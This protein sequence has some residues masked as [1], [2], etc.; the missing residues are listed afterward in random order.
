M[1]LQI[2][3]QQVEGAA[4]LSRV[5]RQALRADA[6]DGS[7]EGAESEALEAGRRLAFEAVVE[8]PAAVGR[9]ALVTGHAPAFQLITDS[10]RQ[11]RRQRRV[12]QAHL[13]RIGG[14]VEHHLGHHP[15]GDA[16]A[17]CRPWV[18]RAAECAAPGHPDAGQERALALALLRALART[19]DTHAVRRESV[20]APYHRRAVGRLQA[21]GTQRQRVGPNS[22]DESL[23]ALV[24]QQ[25]EARRAG[26][27][28]ESQ[29]NFH[30]S[31]VSLVQRPFRVSRLSLGA[32]DR[33]DASR[34]RVQCRHA[35]LRHGAA[36]CCPQ[37]ARQ[38]PGAA[39]RQHGL[40]FSP[41]AP[42]APRKRRCPP[43][44]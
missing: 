25:R 35:C 14:A 39:Q 5:D 40:A 37:P 33:R 30:R 36:R 10:L 29:F 26:G 27:V 43:S 9:A 20:L 21:R 19:A 28:G 22:V 8:L 13:R 44:A 42:C 24:A 23:V 1:G 11:R 7:Q 3:Q 41:S 31:G 2:A 32:S 38:P 18:L 16:I 4:H 34:R 15:P 6:L 12:V 17:Q